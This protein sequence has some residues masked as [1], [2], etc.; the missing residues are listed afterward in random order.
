[1]AQNEAL[2]IE[3]GGGESP[4]MLSIARS[5]LDEWGLTYEVVERSNPQIPIIEFGMSGTY[6]SYRAIV[7]MDMEDQIFAVYYV[8]PLKMIES[9]RR[10][11][12]RYL[13]GANYKVMIGHFDLDFRDG[14]VRFKVSTILRGSM[15]SKEMVKQMIGISMK[16]MDKFFPGMMACEFGDIPADDALAALEN[17]SHVADTSA[18]EATQ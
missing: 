4:N 17:T 7:S 13:A 6:S 1:M 9:R 18:V 15:L 14:E 5:A 11:L 16:T 8:C 10:E 2:T 12:A 3:E